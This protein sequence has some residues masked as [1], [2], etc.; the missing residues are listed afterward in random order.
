VGELCVI[1][2]QNLVPRLKEQLQNGGDCVEK[3]LKVRVTDFFAPFLTDISKKCD[4]VCIFT[5]WTSYVDEPELLTAILDS[6][7]IT[8]T[9]KVDGRHCQITTLKIITDP[10]QENNIIN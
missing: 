5:S 9:K 6:T 1:G 10:S 3:L 4:Y 7:L 8:V 2:I